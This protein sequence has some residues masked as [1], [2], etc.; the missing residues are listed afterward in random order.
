MI[1][2]FELTNHPE[3]DCVETIEAVLTAY[4][5][6][7]AGQPRRDVSLRMSARQPAE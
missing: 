4:D 1:A 6:L 3:I 7:I 2:V 5:A